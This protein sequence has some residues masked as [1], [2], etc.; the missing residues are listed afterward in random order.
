MYAKS[1]KIIKPFYELHQ[2]KLYK[3]VKQKLMYHVTHV[4]YCI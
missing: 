4:F 3:H 1:H 2:T